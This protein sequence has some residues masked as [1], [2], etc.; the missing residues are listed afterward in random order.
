METVTASKHLLF[1]LNQIFELEQKVAKL[2]ESNSLQRNIDRL[3]N[4][5]EVEINEK[6]YSFE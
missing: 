4:Y 3:K 5:F 6:C 2:Q 1:M